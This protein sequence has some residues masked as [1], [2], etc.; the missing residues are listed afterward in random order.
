MKLLSIKACENA[1]MSACRS[2]CPAARRICREVARRG[3]FPHAALSIRNRYFP[4]AVAFPISAYFR[5][6]QVYR[7]CAV[8]PLRNHKRVLAVLIIP[9]LIRF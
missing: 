3:H 1:S 8:R 7:C 4:H 9:K 2:V 5:L 6:F